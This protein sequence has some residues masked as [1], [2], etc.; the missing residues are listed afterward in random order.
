MLHNKAVL[1]KKICVL[2]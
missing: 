2:D 1:D